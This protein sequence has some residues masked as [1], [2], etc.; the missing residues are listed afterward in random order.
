MLDFKYWI[1]K[2]V[3]YDEYYLTK[4]SLQLQPHNNNK[5]LLHI[6]CMTTHSPIAYLGD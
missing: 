2:P 1:T 4:D 6:M 3:E 5:P